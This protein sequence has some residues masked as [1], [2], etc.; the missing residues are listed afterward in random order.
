MGRPHGHL[1]RGR[2]FGATP[3]TV[4]IARKARPVSGTAVRRDPERCWRH[5]A[6][7]VRAGLARRVVVVGAESTGTTTMA[8]ALAEH[9]QARGGVWSGTQWVPEYGR[10][11]SEEKYASLLAAS[12]NALFADV[13]WTSP[14]FELIAERQ[15]ADENAAAGAGS[16]VLFCDTDPLAT[17]I[18]HERYMGTRNPQVESIAARANHHLWLLTDDEGV[19]FEDGGLRDGEHVRTWMTDRFREELT[20]RNLPHILLTGPHAD[21]LRTAVTAVDTLLTTGWHFT[22]SLP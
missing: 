7:P 17:T 19:P 8:R 9:Y 21:R 18:W 6:A 3:V 1:P 20:G 4:D 22:A 13:T 10:A 5:L 15:L 11:Y 16:P 2:R 12:P 14:D